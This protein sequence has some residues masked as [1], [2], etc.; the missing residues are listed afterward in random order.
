MLALASLQVPSSIPLCSIILTG[1]LCLGEPLD[2]LQLLRTLYLPLLPR[3][4]SLPVPP[5]ACGLSGGFRLSPQIQRGRCLLQ[6]V[7]L[8]FP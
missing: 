8:D 6:K 4:L 7:F 2:S 5:L 1:L 3:D